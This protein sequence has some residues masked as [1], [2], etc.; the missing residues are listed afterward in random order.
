MDFAEQG[1]NCKTKCDEIIR[2]LNLES[3][4]ATRLLE[5]GRMGAYYQVALENKDNTAL[6]CDQANVMNGLEYIDL[7]LS[8]GYPVVVGI[9]HTFRKNKKKN[10]N[11][12]EYTTDHFVIIVGRHCKDG[13]TYYRFWDVGSKN[14]A[15]SDYKFILDINNRL[16]CPENYNKVRID[17]TQVRRNKQL[18]EKKLI[19]INFL[20]N[21]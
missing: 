4:G 2:V 7:S 17:V 14:G 1:D 19:D 8:M 6:I 9:N 12:N 20:K 13:V 11:I 15:E 10:Q 18:P 16:Y 21:K 3:E 5:N